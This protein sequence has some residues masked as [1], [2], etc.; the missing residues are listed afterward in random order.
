VLAS[1]VASGGKGVAFAA[2]S[3]INDID[4]N[5]LK[6]ACTPHWRARKNDKL[7]LEIN[8]TLTPKPTLRPTPRQTP[9]PKN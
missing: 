7:R 1:D 3:F 5:R 4:L 9:T 8:L 6:N 2:T